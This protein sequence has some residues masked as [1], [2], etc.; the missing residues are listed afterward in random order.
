MKI[1]SFR[2]SLNEIPGMRNNND[3]RHSFSL[4]SNLPST[5]AAAIKVLPK[6]TLNAVVDFSA[7]LRFLILAIAVV[8]YLRTLVCSVA[9]NSV[10]AKKR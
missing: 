4:L 3:F 2:Q 7:A 10:K 6:L 8:D 9:I 1:L 5:H